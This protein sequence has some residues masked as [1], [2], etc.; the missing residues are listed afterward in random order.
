M[1]L[2]K[3][4]KLR[5]AYIFKDR[6]GVINM[7]N[8]GLFK[9]IIEK[10]KKEEEQ[11]KFQKLIDKCKEEKKDLFEKIRLEIFPDL[12]K[13]IRENVEKDF[14]NYLKQYNIK[15]DE[16]KQANNTLIASNGYIQL[17][18][19]ELKHPKYICEINLKLDE[20]IF[21]IFATLKGF[22]PEVKSYINKNE[23]QICEEEKQELENILKG[24]Y[25]VVYFLTRPKA[26]RKNNFFDILKEIDKEG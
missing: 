15:E 5:Q 25:Q 13:E 4:D 8:K 1:I 3:L 12:C 19:K 2:N 21:D 23:L 22:E 20:K 6:G 16:I 9:E 18:I 26:I 10:A 17:T 11:K 7:K 24:N 14:I